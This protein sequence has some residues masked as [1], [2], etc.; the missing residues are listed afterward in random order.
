M[1]QN[2]TLAYV[3]GPSIG[4]DRELV[5]I[6]RTGVVT[7]VDSGWTA[8]IRGLP[9]LSPDGRAVAFA[10]QKGR[11]TEVW[12]KALNDG[13]LSKFAD[14][15]ASPTWSPDGREVAFWVP[16]GYAFGPADGS[17]LPRVK[18]PRTDVWQNLEISR[19]GQWIV[20]HAGGNIVAMRTNGDSA[21][22]PLLTTAAL[23]RRGTL[24]P[25]SRWLAY[26]SDEGGMLQVYVRPFPDTERT[27]RQVSVRGG[28]APRWSRDGRELYFIDPESGT[29]VA[30]PVTLAPMFSTGQPQ[31]LFPIPLSSAYDVRADGRFLV[32][33]ATLS[34]ERTAPDLVVVT[35]FPAEL[36]ARVP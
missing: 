12:I 19:D 17:V 8:P 25:D 32:S 9:A 3:A 30:V 4:L 15:G 29:L 1:A 6:S 7:P 35:N 14:R 26:E 5:W 13:P 20:G 33:R 22:V 24:S 23:E 21:L 31:S 28:M 16:G 27:K 2:G 36:R 34:R 11:S 10:L 18:Y